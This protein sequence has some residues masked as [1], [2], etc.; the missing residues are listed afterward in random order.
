MWPTADLVTFSEKILNGNL[1]CA[2]PDLSIH[3]ATSE[4]I[5]SRTKLTPDHNFRMWIGMLGILKFAISIDLSTSVIFEDVFKSSEVWFL[6]SSFFLIRINFSIPIKLYKTCLME[7]FC[8]LPMTATLQDVFYSNN[9]KARSGN[10]HYNCKQLEFPN[11]NSLIF[12]CISQSSWVTL[13]YFQ[14]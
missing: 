12:L 7:I 13:S 3:G 11:W 2:V 1:F 8:T 9:N 5:V 4:I 10:V 6:A 14:T